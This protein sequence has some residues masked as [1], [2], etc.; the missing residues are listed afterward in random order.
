MIKFPIERMLAVQTNE[1]IDEIAHHSKYWMYNN[2]NDDPRC[3]KFKEKKVHRDFIR[4]TKEYRSNLMEMIQDRLLKYNQSRKR[5]YDKKRVEPTNYNSFERVGIDWYVTTEGNKK[6]LA[7]HHRTAEIMDR[8]GANSYIV[9]YCDTGHYHP[10]NVDRMHKLLPIDDVSDG[11]TR[12]ARRHVRQSV[13]FEM[14]RKRRRR[15]NTSSKK[16][17]RDQNI[18]IMQDLNLNK[19]RKR[20]KKN[21]KSMEA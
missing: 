2:P 7:L 12:S 6:K 17:L 19:P 9:R 5:W 11:L 14:R 4:F 21:K 8:I 16:R 10:V 13:T 3:H 18:E 20:H 15:I 1:Q